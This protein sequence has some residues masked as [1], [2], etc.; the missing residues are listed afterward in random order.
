L[1]STQLATLAAE[2]PA[3]HF[4]L[5]RECKKIGIQKNKNMHR[6]KSKHFVKHFGHA[7]T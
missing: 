6:K 1:S 5:L 7:K 3:R 4:L 2:S